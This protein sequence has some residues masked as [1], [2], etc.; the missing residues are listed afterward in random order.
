MSDQ[1]SLRLDSSALWESHYAAGGTSGTGSYGRL[2]EFKAE[3]INQLLGEHHIKSVLELGCGDGHQLS[4]I[5][6]PR[7]LGIDTSTTAIEACRDRFG[8][9]PTKRF[10]SYRPGDRIVERADMSVSLDVIYHL[11]EDSVFEEYMRDLFSVARRLVVV[12]SSD[13]E[14]ESE[15]PEVRHRH[16]TQWVEEFAPDWQLRERIPNRHPYVLGDVDSSW[17]DFYVY[18]KRPGRLMRWLRPR[19]RKTTARASATEDFLGPGRISR[20]EGFAEPA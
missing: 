10:V 19:P 18:Q 1:S 7:Y 17:S 6:Y 9:D 16:F 14:D 13:G 3:V 20:L 8:E 5:R 12:Y 11:F 15:W 4:L 2:A